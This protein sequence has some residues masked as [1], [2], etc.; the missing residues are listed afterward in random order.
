MMRSFYLSCFVVISSGCDS[1]ANLK[2]GGFEEAAREQIPSSGAAET[3]F[4]AQESEAIRPLPASIASNVV[5]AW[6]A[7]DAQ[8]MTN[9][10]GVPYME[11]V[12][13]FM[14]PRG[15][16]VVPGRP[17]R[18]AITSS[19]PEPDVPFG[20]EII[21]DEPTEA[22]IQELARFKHLQWLELF[23]FRWAGGMRRLNTL[24]QLKAL[25]ID[26]NSLAGPP[27][28]IAASTLTDADAEGLATIQQLRALQAH[29]AA[30]TDDGLRHLVGLKNLEWLDLSG[31]PITDDG[32][33]HFQSLTNIKH[34]DLS[35]TKIRGIGLKH[36]ASLKSL[37]SLNLTFTSLTDDGLKDVARLTQLQSLT[38]SNNR[39]TDAALNTVG[40][41]KHLKSLAISGNP[42]MTPQAVDD[43]RRQ[44]PA[45]KIW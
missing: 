34:L 44:M 25:V 8:Q 33:Q 36:L 43:L 3:T 23:R 4:V 40:A 2:T 38:L 10:N 21:L 27:S 32:L 15:N 7:A 18:A 6:R 1:S 26:A 45:T 28:F 31:A 20:L 24:P 17:F 19:L 39:L 11:H 16:S 9:V 29:G 37:R 35:G 13:G 41:M 42:L 30:L 22:D 12:P 14:I 5:T